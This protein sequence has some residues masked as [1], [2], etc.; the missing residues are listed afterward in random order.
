MTFPFNDGSQRLF[1]WNCPEA[2]EKQ[3]LQ[4]FTLNILFSL[5]TYLY[6]I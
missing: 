6:L 1:K 2:K 5:Q 4:T 3:K